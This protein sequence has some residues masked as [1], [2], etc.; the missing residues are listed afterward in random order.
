MAEILARDVGLS[1]SVR[2]QRFRRARNP[3]DKLRQERYEGGDPDEMVELVRRSSTGA[4]TASTLSG[5]RASGTA[6]R[7]RRSGRR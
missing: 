7:P 1:S 2:A 6:D 5:R 3:V 4:T